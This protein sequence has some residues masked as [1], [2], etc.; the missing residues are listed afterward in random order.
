MAGERPV[1]SLKR[2]LESEAGTPK[3]LRLGKKVIVEA[4]R[5]NKKKKDN[6][7]K[8]PLAAPLKSVPIKANKPPRPKRPQRTVPLA[9]AETLLAQWWPTLLTDGGHPRLM[10]QGIRAD[11]HQDIALRQLPV[12]HKHLHRCLKAITR[13]PGYLGQSVVL[14]PRY[15][16]QGKPCGTVTPGEQQFAWARL[17]AIWAQRSNDAS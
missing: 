10:K 1:L 2:K 9:D 6:R 16:L 4:T 17:S 12:S 13:A 11:F 14:A 3:S 5:P 15:D 7:A 8:A